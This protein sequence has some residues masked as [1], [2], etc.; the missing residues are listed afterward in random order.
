MQVNGHA[1]AETQ[2]KIALGED[3]YLWYRGPKSVNRVA[4]GG[5]RKEK[6]SGLA[7]YAYLLIWRGTLD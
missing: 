2:G 7:L 5:E 3:D 6:D 1:I 4:A